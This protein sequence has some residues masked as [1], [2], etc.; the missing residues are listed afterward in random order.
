MS[1]AQPLHTLD[2]V[3]DVLPQVRDA[4][5]THSEELGRK[6]RSL[7]QERDTLQIQVGSLTRAFDEYR[8]QSS[9]A[10]A[11]VISEKEAISRER[12][13]LAAHLEEA[14][15][16]TENMYVKLEDIKPKV[17]MEVKSEESN[18]NGGIFSDIMIKREYPEDD[19]IERPTKLRKLSS[20]APRAMKMEVVIPKPARRSGSDSRNM[21]KRLTSPIE[22]ESTTPFFAHYAPIF[23]FESSNGGARRV[24]AKVPVLTPHYI[25]LF[26]LDRLSTARS[27]LEGPLLGTPHF[28]QVLWKTEVFQTSTRLA[29]LLSD[30]KLLEFVPFITR[31]HNQNEAGLPGLGWPCS[32]KGTNNAL[33]AWVWGYILRFIILDMILWLKGY[34]PASG[35]VR[36]TGGAPPK[37]AA[38]FTNKLHRWEKYLADAAVLGE[39]NPA[40][41]TQGYENFRLTA[42]SFISVIEEPSLPPPGLAPDIADAFVPARFSKEGETPGLTQAV[43]NR[44]LAVWLLISPLAVLVDDDLSAPKKVSHE[45]ISLAQRAI[46][47]ARPLRIAIAERYMHSVLFT[48]LRDSLSDSR[49]DVRAA[50]ERTTGAPEHVQPLHVDSF[51]AA[52]SG[53]WGLDV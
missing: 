6:C 20:G 47:T 23:D 14:L 24:E 1:D 36:P 28:F 48:L 41:A 13:S 53:K 50:F 44:H 35:A 15:K 7:E 39:G 16:G 26:D 38:P 8:V 11:K 3:L 37:P 33:P 51:F 5:R 10:M 49:L 42:L 22:R 30:A 52:I 21:V 18:L 43:L 46:G 17:K 32:E 34:K 45:Q 25:H 31:L 29:A 27:R 19:D 2:T 12:D 4:Y 40:D 9:V